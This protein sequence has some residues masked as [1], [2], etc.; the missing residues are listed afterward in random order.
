MSAGKWHERHG[1][2]LPRSNLFLFVHLH[3]NEVLKSKG[4][5]DRDD[6]STARLK[7]P[8]TFELIVNLRAAEATG[9]DLP[10]GVLARA[11]ELIE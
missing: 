5:T 2:K 6:H 10:Q 1:K 4:G 11:D 8:S 7:L 9:M 3:K